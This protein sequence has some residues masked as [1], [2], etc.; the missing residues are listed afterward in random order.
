MPAIPAAGAQAGTRAGVGAAAA[1]VPLFRP[2]APPAAVREL[3]SAEGLRP[4]AP[5]LGVLLDAAA[6]SRPEIF[7]PRLRR[8]VVA[9]EPVAAGRRG[10]SAAPPAP[11]E[12]IDDAEGRRCSSM[13]SLEGCG[14]PLWLRDRSGEEE[15]RRPR[16]PVR[17]RSGV[18]VMV[19]VT[20]RRITTKVI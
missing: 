7:A 12:V 9:V 10:C 14:L 2:A 18:M 16:L 17:S 15:P 8:G 20:H 11:G 4:A 19:M 1:P 5:P 6:T 3:A 13:G